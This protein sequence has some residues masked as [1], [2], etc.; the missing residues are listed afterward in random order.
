MKAQITQILDIHEIWPDTSASI[1]LILAS[2]DS[3]Q[4]FT[5]WAER[6]S[7]KSILISNKYFKD[8]GNAHASFKLLTDVLVEIYDPLMVALA[9]IATTDPQ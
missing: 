4:P 8:Q 1:L 9:S 3:E 5:I 7:D 6:K 2:T